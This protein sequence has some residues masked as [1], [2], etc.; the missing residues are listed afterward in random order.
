MAYRTVVLD[1]DGTCTD[2]ERE[3]QGF[4]AAYK[5][6]L[7]RVLDRADI[8]SAW[9][10]KEA[11]ILREP[12]RHGMVF[13]GQIVAPAVDLYLLSTAIAVLIAP[14]LDDATS[15]RLFTENYRYTETAFKHE[16]LQVLETLLAK[17]LNCFVVTNSNRANVEAKLARLAL[18]DRSKLSL[19][20]SARKYR[21]SD[22]ERFPDDRRFARLPSSLPLD[23]WARPVHPRRGAYFDALASI[24]QETGSTPAETL[25]VGDVFELDLLLPALLGCGLHLTCSPRT[26]AYERRAVEGFGGL[27]DP[28]LRAVL[29]RL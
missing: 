20:G 26:L 11:Q 14:D 25:V 16:T 10:E 21:L 19:R 12:S 15:E 3:A 6:D 1:F 22:P 18:T 27:T 2:V 5:A 8:E 13:H 28:D 4:L 9:Q 29:E 23:G 7:G 24:W 17:D